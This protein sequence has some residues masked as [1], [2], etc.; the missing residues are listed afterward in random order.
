MFAGIVDVAVRFR[1]LATRALLR[2]GFREY[3]FL[4]LIA[5]LVGMVTAGAAVLFHEL[6]VHLREVLFAAPGED[7]LYGRGLFMLVLIPTVGGIVVGVL[8]KLVFKV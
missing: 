3:S 2:L 4:I 1:V 8:S 5:V 7:W 6:I